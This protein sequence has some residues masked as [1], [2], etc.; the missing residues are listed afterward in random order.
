MDD[1]LKEICEQ[2]WEDYYQEMRRHSHSKLRGHYEDAEDVVQTAFK[3]LWAKMLKDDVP[4]SPQ[5]WLHKTIGYLVK[6]QYRQYEKEK[7]CIPLSSNEETSVSFAL[8]VDDKMAN[9]QLY[10]ELWK[11][12]EEELNDD[13]KTLIK[14]SIFEEKG[15]KET[16]A[17]LGI[18][19]TATKQRKYRLMRKTHQMSERKKKELNF[20]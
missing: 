8:D 16:A 5:A 13:E 3:L 10:A 1:S 2:I 9:E 6:M 17:L 4:V 7:I 15:N 12:F 18:S 14:Y 19:E 20:F 11:I